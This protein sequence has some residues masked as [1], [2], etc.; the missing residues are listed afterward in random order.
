MRGVI[1]VLVGQIK[2]DDRAAV[3]VNAKVQ[4]APG[5][6]F[7]SSMFFKQPF[8]RSAQLQPRAVDDQVKVARFRS[9][10]GLSRQSARPPAQRRMIGDGQVDF[11]HSHDRANQPFALAERQS[12]HRSQ[13]QRC[14]NGEIGIMRLAAPRRP[15]LRLP[16]RQRFFGEPDRQ[17]S[18]IAKRCVIIPPIGHSM[19]L[20]GNVAPALG[21]KLERHDR[22]PR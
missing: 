3:G 19:P 8:A 22:P 10:V 12:K 6:A 9:P 11:Q 7:R 2:C 21:M 13:C 4:L 18:T 5:A 14:F 1:D 16:T 15:G 20:T 17:A